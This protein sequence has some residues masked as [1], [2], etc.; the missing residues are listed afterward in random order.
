MLPA[1]F[2]KPNTVT[3][4]RGFVLALFLMGVLGTGAE[5]LLLEHTEDTWQ[6]IPLI[7]MALSLVV[8]GWCVVDRRPRSMRA[9]QGTMLLFVLGGSVGLWLHVQSNVEFELEMYPSMAGLELFW[10]AAMGALPVLAPGAMIQLGLLGLA[11][12]YRHPVLVAAVEMKS[13]N[14]GG[15]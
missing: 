11:Y 4:L 15:T 9:F 13:D 2:S 5:L 14:H 8:L 7:L 3:A 1:V 10:E 12:T 6:W